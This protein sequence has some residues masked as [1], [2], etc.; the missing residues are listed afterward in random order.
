MAPSTQCDGVL[1]AMLMACH[2]LVRLLKQSTYYVNVFT[3]Y[4]LL[5]S[6]LTQPARSENVWD[7]SA[8]YG[9]Q[10]WVYMWRLPFVFFSAFIAHRVT[11]ERYNLSSPYANVS[12][13]QDVI[14]M[15]LTLYIRVV[16]ICT[17][18]FNNHYRCVL[19]LWVSDDVHSEQ[20]LFP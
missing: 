4:Q 20:G 1:P 11:D 17:I 19:H 16:T 13:M 12:I 2:A 15:N 8:G 3:D 10:V 18:R 5:A 6:V 14:L 9:I 7:I